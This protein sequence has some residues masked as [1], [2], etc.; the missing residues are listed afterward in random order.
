[1]LALRDYYNEKVMDSP[2]KHK[3]IEDKWALNYIDPNRTQLIMEAFDN[4]SSGFVTV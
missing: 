4:D 3:V 2:D 1:M